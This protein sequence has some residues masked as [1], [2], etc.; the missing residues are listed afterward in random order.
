MQYWRWEQQYSFAALRQAAIDHLQFVVDTVAALTNPAAAIV[1]QSQVSSQTR[2]VG[3]ETIQLQP[4]DTAPVVTQIAP[5]HIKNNS[6]QKTLRITGSG[7][8]PD[9]VVRVGSMDPLTPDAVSSTTLRVTLPAQAP[10][11][12]FSVV[13]TNPNSGLDVAQQ[14]QSGILNNAI[15]IATPPNFKP[16]LQVA[17]TNFGDST[18]S[19][20]HTVKDDT[21]TP[22]FPTRGLPIPL[23]ISP[24]GARAYIGGPFTPATV[25]VFNFSTNS[26]EAR[27]VINGQPSSR[28][29][30][31]KGIVFAPRLATGKLAA[32]VIA[33]KR[34]GLDLYAI[35]GPAPT[36]VVVRP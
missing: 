26:I 21:T 13:V 33:S 19:L 8:A 1:H 6:S 11:G 27:V 10:A 12:T 24:D 4:P 30:Q 22:R 29:G 15:T 20:L 17:V 25:E 5:D 14:Q 35:V 3:T 7:F 31:A 2:A 36:Y 9:A 34:R 32:Y 16:A 23:A 28:V 18:L